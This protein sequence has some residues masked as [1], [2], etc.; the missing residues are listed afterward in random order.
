MPAN[1]AIK[2]LRLLRSWL[3][4]VIISLSQ[5]V[6]NSL[7]YISF[8]L[9]SLG[10]LYVSHGTSPATTVTLAL[11]TG[12]LAESQSLAP[13]G[14]MILHYAG[15]SLLLLHLEEHIQPAR[16]NYLFYGGVPILTGSVN[17]L[18]TTT[19][20]PHLTRWHLSQHLLHTS[21]SLTIQTILVL[22]WIAWR[23]RRS[24]GGSS[25]PDIPYP[26]SRN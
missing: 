11:L 2:A 24:D 10:W 1:P 6:L 7:G 3:L 4:L 20:Y 16:K 18:L 15:L 26:H 12:L 9:L 13:Q 5:L 22:G 25:H 23:G 19:L 17:M 8:D 21:F 14:M